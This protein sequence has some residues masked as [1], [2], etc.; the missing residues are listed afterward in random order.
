[1]SVVQ[2]PVDFNMTADEVVTVTQTRLAE[3]FRFDNG[4]PVVLENFPR[5]AN[6][7]AV[8][9]FDLAVTQDLRNANPAVTAVPFATIGSEF[10]GNETLPGSRFGVYTSQPN[11]GGLDSRNELLR[12][13]ND[14]V[15]WVVRSVCISM[16]SLWVWLSVVSRRRVVQGLPLSTTRITKR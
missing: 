9:F 4:D 10:A 14:H 8:R 16:T 5:I 12:A 1:M 6:T 2:I 13:V 7:N 15:D 11:T 3:T